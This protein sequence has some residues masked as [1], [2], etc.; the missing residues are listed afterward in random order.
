MTQTELENTIID[1][2]NAAI[3]PLGAQ[4]AGAR[5]ELAEIKGLIEALP[6]GGGRGGSKGSKGPN[7]AELTDVNDGIF[8]IARVYD[9]NYKGQMKYS[10][11]IDGGVKVGAW[12]RDFPALANGAAK[13]AEGRNI[14]IRYGKNAKGYYD[15]V[16]IGGDV[17]PVNGASAPADDDLP[18]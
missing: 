10:F 9:D 2:V 8:K 12:E 4:L 14:R 6:K 15:A 18:F 16:A 7:E 11:Q 3:A 1:A 17:Q 13:K 5:S